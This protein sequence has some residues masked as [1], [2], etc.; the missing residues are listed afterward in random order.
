MKGEF[1]TMDKQFYTMKEL[2]EV[3][4]IGTTNLYNLVHSAG[5]PSITI[6]RKIVIPVEEFNQWIKSSAGKKIKL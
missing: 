2:G 6:N 3:L 1:K 5:F 4:P